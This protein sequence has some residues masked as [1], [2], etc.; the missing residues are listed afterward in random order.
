[1]IQKALLNQNIQG[2]LHYITPIYCQHP[3]P[4]LRVQKA[5]VDQERL[6]NR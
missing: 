3:A 1:M 6:P 4:I 5:E 2:Q